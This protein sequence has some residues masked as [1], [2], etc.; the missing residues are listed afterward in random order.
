MNVIKTCRKSERGVDRSG[1]T[2]ARILSLVLCGVMCLALLLTAAACGKAVTDDGNVNETGDQKGDG[3]KV[4]QIKVEPAE[5]DIGIWYSVW[6]TYNDDYRNNIKSNIW[7]NWDI[8][9]EPLLP[10]G[11]F[12]YYDSLDEEVIYFHLK[13]LSEAGVD[14]IIMDQTN[15][16][17][18]EGGFINDR[19][20]KMAQCIK[21]WNDEGNRPIKYCSAI[22]KIQ[23]DHNGKAIEDEA[24][25]LYNRYLKKDFGD[26]YYMLDGKPLLIIYGDGGEQLWADYLAEGGR[27]K[28]TD[29]FTL[30]WADNQSTPGYYGWAYDKGTKQDGEVMVVMPGWDNRKGHTPVPRDNGR[31]YKDS[32]K[33][34][35]TAK[36]KPKIIV[37]N[38]FNEYAENTGVFTA[39]TDLYGDDPADMYWNMT[40]EYI[41]IFREG[42]IFDGN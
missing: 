20:L 18:T 35:F 27:T 6:Y 16:I 4:G 30:R 31:W 24:V 26:A 15:I 13:E 14:F 8:Q 17:D 28:Y 36:T 38:S 37:I 9:Y 1:R 23:W 42:G 39:K 7:L 25:T 29:Q 21:K 12:G 5:A 11:S 22:G 34:V 2:A 19:A 10:D 32:W 40:K 33:Q 3:L 41:K